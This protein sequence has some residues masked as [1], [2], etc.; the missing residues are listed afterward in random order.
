[1]SKALMAKGRDWDTVLVLVRTCPARKIIRYPLKFQQCPNIMSKS[2]ESEELELSY[3]G[4]GY[5]TLSQKR[6]AER[7]VGKA[8]PLRI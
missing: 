7:L 3:D 4:D 6:N 1:M 2:K 5:K 8:F